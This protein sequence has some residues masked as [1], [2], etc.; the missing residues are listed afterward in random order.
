MSHPPLDPYAGQGPVH[1]GAEPQFPFAEAQAALTAIQ[2]LLDQLMALDNSR[3]SAAGD[4][5]A[6]S[7]G[8]SITNFRTRNDELST[9]LTNSWG[10]RGSALQ[11]DAQWVRDAI[12]Q[13]HTAHQQWKT[14]L[15]AHDRWIRDHPGVPP[16]QGPR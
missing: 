13:A 10:Q 8:S 11:M 14:Q 4:M 7:S 5:L 16:T 12:A 3:T 15:D 6:T 1:P 9:G 2:G